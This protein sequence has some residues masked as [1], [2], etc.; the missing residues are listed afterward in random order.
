V[1]MAA[2]II[3]SSDGEGNSP[4]SNDWESFKSFHKKVFSNSDQEQIRK[5]T[6]QKNAKEV[7]RH[8]KLYD[9]GKVSYALELNEFSDQD[10]KSFSKSHNGYKRRNDSDEGN[11][12]REIFSKADLPASFDWR[13]KNGVSPVKHQSSCG[14]CYA[15]AAVGAIESQVKIKGR[16]FQALS[17]QQIID[18]DKNNGG[19]NGGDQVAAMRYVQSAGGIM[20]SSAY[21]Y[22]AKSGSCKFDKGKAV[23]QVTGYKVASRSVKDMMTTLV[24]VGPLAISIYANDAFQKYSGGI[25]SCRSSSVNHAVLLVGYGT[26]NGKDYWLVKNS[27]GTRWGLEGFFKLSRDSGKDCG[28]LVEGASYPRI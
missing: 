13:E 3:R 23:T 12:P 14:S 24:N 21:P 18:C 26:E 6:F 17:E 11:L 5:S 9:E 20:S 15:F 8:N 10:S 1:V 2:A 4:E 28:V 22:K 16:N 25:Y 7:D 19:C 27:Y